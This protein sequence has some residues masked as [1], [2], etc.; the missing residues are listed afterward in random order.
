MAESPTGCAR[1]RRPGSSRGSTCR[2]PSCSRFTPSRTRTCAR[3]RGCWGERPESSNVWNGR[4]ERP[5]GSIRDDQRAQPYLTKV[6]PSRG[7]LQP[8]G[9]HSEWVRADAVPGSTRAAPSSPRRPSIARSP[10][11]VSRSSARGRGGS[12]AAFS[13][14]ATRTAATTPTSRSVARP[15]GR[16]ALTPAAWPRPATHRGPRWACCTLLSRADL[17]G[18]SREAARG[19]PGLPQGMHAGGGLRPARRSGRI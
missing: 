15:T 5:T 12:A 16:R 10:R 17:V 2:C 13:D 19:D 1:G 7:P 8:T 14:P 6:T 9:H 11:G 3:T 18:L 4:G